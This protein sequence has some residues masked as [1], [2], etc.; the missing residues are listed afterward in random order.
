VLVHVRKSNLFS[1]DSGVSVSCVSAAVESGRRRRMGRGMVAAHE[2]FAAFFLSRRR[3]S[4][5]FKTIVRRIEGASQTKSI[6]RKRID[7]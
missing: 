5:T 1:S 7:N 4:S 3:K 6:R 2:I